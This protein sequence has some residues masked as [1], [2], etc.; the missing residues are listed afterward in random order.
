MVVGVPAMRILS[1]SFLFA[2]IC[3]V[4]GS[5]CQAL[6]KSMYSFWVSFGRQLV[7]LIPVALLLS[8]IFHDVKAVWWAFPIAEVVSLIMSLYF[9]RRVLKKLSWNKELVSA[10]ADE[11][12]TDA[13]ADMYE[14]E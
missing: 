3:I 4:S 2:G 6:G 11:P 14:Y 5:V 13:D 9:V 12:F 1:L 10:D 8:W 7:A